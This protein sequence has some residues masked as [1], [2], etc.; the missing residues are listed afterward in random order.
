MSEGM[1]AIA[2]VDSEGLKVANIQNPTESMLISNDGNMGQ[3]HFLWNSNGNLLAFADEEALK[4]LDTTTGDT[5]LLI[6]HEFVD[7][8]TGGFK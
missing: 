4:L 5:R 7:S 6:K 2:F 1:Q 3:R 8:G